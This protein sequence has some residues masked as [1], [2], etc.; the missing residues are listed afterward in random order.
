MRDTCVLA[1]LIV[2]LCAMTSVHAASEE[3]STG[4][5]VRRTNPS[6]AFQ[7][8]VE[9]FYPVESKKLNEQ[10]VVRVQMCYDTRGNFISNEV[11]ESSGFPRLDEAAVQ[12]SRKFRLN[13]GT[14][15]GVSVSG[16][17]ATSIT[18]R[19]TGAGAPPPLPVKPMAYLY[20][21]N[22]SDFYPSKSKASGEEGL[23]EVNICYNT[24]GKVHDAAV[25][26]SS[27]FARL[28]KAAIRAAKKFRI[29]P[30]ALYGVPQAG[31]KVVPIS[32]LLHRSTF[33]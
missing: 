9:D 25:A 20:R 26:T 13:P 15:D 4:A 24:K 21:P 10:G 6:I 8:N 3:T 5:A 33:D 7:P 27:G 22:I 16:C 12:A 29:S 30:A 28:D 18:F 14:V 11:K 23:V 31:C 2:T 32:F 19:L 17:V 1:S